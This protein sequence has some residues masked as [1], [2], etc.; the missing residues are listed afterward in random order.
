MSS[1]Q[2]VRQPDRAGAYPV[3]A[4]G[5]GEKPRA[6]GHDASPGKAVYRFLA[7]APAIIDGTGGFIRQLR[8]NWNDLTASWC[9]DHSD[10]SAEKS[11]S[12]FEKS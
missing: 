5:E 2:A 3:R 6:E 10:C 8:G 1:E 11:S 4:A 12:S 7:L 9:F